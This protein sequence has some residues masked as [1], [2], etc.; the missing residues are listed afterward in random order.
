MARRFFGFICT[1][2]MTASMGWATS[3]QKAEDQTATGKFLTATEVKPILAATQGNWV[4]VREYNGQD[5]VYFTHLLAWRCGL[6]EISFSINGQQQ[7]NFEIPACDP[8]A[9]APGAI[10]DTATIYLE[11]PLNSVQTISVSLLYDDLSTQTATF[12]RANIMTP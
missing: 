3:P 10:P 4:A 1:A 2:I 5:L 9:A 8:D 12:E 7:Q 11:Y 6:Y